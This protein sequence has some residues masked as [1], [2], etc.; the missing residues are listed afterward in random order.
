MSSNK[1]SKRLNYRSHFVILYAIESHQ[2]WATSGVFELLSFG[3]WGLLA[4]MP[5]GRSANVVFRVFRMESERRSTP[6]LG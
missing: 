6:T 4:G 2:P 1:A 5:L 3:A